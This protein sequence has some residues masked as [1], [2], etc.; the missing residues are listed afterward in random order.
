MCLTMIA[1]GWLS[2]INS[3]GLRRLLEIDSLNVSM[4]NNA[5]IVMHLKEP[6]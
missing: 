3:G 1:F 2:I 6:D 5:E 4:V